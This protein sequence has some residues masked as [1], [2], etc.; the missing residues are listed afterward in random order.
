MTAPAENFAVPTTVDLRYKATSVGGWG[1]AFWI[2]AD[3][4]SGSTASLIANLYKPDATSQ[5]LW[6]G[7][8]LANGTIAWL[9]TYSV[10]DDFVDVRLV[11][12]PVADTMAV[13][14]DGEHKD[15]FNYFWGSPATGTK[16]W[17]YTEGVTAEFDYVRIRVGGTSP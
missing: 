13:F 10:P 17:V 4:H 2:N 11:I 8:E 14:T 7:H 15:T 3:R 1:A 9:K 6:I 5:Q 16:A 12:D